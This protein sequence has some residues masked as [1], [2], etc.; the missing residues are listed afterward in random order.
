[1]SFPAD[2]TVFAFF[3]DL[4]PTS[5]HSMDSCFDHGLYVYT[6]CHVLKH[7]FNLVCHKT[8]QALL[9][10]C[11]PNAIMIRREHAWHQEFLC[12][13]SRY[14]DSSTV[15]AILLTFVGHL[16]KSYRALF[17]HFRTSFTW[18]VMGTFTAAV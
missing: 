9:V 13:I 10:K 7:K 15:S 17:D 1:M 12:E 3:G 14:F 18:I 6:H 8:H 5:T 11:R 16:P 2:D 4:E